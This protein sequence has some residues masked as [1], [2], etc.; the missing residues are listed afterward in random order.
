MK[1]FAIITGASRGIGKDV[2]NFFLEEEYDVSLIASNKELLDKVSE[3]F[4]KKY[5]SAKIQAHAF[6][7][8]CAD[9]AY[10]LTKSIIEKHT[11]TVDVLFNCAGTAELGTSEISIAQF[12]RIQ[13]V[14]VNG[15]FA[16]AKAVAEKMK[17]QGKGY[18]INLA[19]IC[20]KTGFTNLGAY[21]ASKFAVV[22]LSQSLHK[23]LAKYGIKVTA[24]CP[25]LTHT[26]MSRNY[27]APHE[28][29]I[30][31]SDIVKSVKYLLSLGPTALI[32]SLDIHCRIQVE[33][34]E[35]FY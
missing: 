12:E 11:G 3:D 7:I 35:S 31:T 1:K 27:N 32:D 13:S 2:A 34:F 10:Q 4:T 23:E 28:A 8:G 17:H 24:I 9:K 15:N 21:S 18:I 33:E 25:G 14:N 16:I 19:S 22:G 6:D 30:Q 26:D 20:G 5:P 29:K